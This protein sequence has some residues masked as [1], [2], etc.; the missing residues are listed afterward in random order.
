M[1]FEDILAT[2]KYSYMLFINVGWGGGGSSN[3]LKGLV[4]KTTSM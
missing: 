4:E 1:L 3:V 2:T